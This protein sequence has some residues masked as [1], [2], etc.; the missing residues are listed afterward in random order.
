MKRRVFVTSENALRNGGNQWETGYH[1][2]P[3]VNSLTG[4]G[5]GGCG[6]M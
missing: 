6:V 3:P 2:N 1:D 5:R 4:G